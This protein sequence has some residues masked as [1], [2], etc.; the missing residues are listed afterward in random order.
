[1]AYLEEEGYISRVHT[2]AGAQPVD[3][4]YRYYVESLLDTVALPPEEQRLLYHLF[5]QIAREMDQWLHLAA[6]MLARMAINVA[7]VTPPHASACRFKHV[8]LVALQEFLALVVLVLR[9][10]KLKHQ[11]LPLERA[12]T[13][14]ELSRLAEELNSSFDDLTSND[15]RKAAQKKPALGKPILGK[16]T[17]PRLPATPPLAEEVTGAILGMMESE[18]AQ[19]EESWYLEGLHLMLG[20]PEFAQGQR[21]R[22]VMEMVAERKLL[23]QAIQE[24]LREREVR[25]IIGAENELERMRDYSLVVTRYGVVGEAG[26]IL[27]VIGPTRMRYE[28]VIATL[29]YLSLLM[30]RLLAEVF[31]RERQEY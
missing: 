31:G 6:S 11:L 7:L 20:Q 8:E 15:I 14:E 30:S 13:Q 29:S 25:V 5:H 10:A 22:S 21:V 19:R 16:G 4:G 26:G 28:R 27:G 9:Q 1:M 2:S 3:K 24:V 12:A 23:R 18:D 17:T